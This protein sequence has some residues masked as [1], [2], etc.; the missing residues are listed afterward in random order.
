MRLQTI[1]SREV[2]SSN[3][4]AVVTVGSIHAGATENVILD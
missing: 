2:S 1:L 4:F 3:E